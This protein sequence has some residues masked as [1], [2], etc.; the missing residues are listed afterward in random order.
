[1]R[2]NSNGVQYFKAHKP[3]GKLTYYW[4]PPKSLWKAGIFRFVTLGGDITAPIAEA[5]Q[6]NKKLDAYYVSI[7]G[8]R[9][10]LETVKPMRAAFI[11]RSFE[12]THKFNKYSARTRKE[13]SRMYC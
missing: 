5:K 3:N 11:A 6:W 2:P 13:Y 4:I 7:R 12:A 9:T 1:M 8:R 10:R